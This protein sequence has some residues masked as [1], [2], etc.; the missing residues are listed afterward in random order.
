MKGKR[1]GRHATILIKHEGIEL[2]VVLLARYSLY[3]L[4]FSFSLIVAAA[5]G[6]GIAFSR[7]NE[8]VGNGNA[9]AG[10]L[11]MSPMREG[12]SIHS[13]L[14]LGVEDLTK[15]KRKDFKLPRQFCNIAQ[16]FRTFNN[17]RMTV[18]FS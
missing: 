2:H 3:F 5:Y 7:L 17:F 8:R 9:V 18:R 10:I 16:A 11:L 1:S 4:I 14:V 13:T 6:S 15:A 12:D